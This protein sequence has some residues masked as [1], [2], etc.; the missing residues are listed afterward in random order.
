[1]KGSAV[2]IRSPASIEI[3]GKLGF[4]VG[5]FAVGTASEPEDGN[6]LEALQHA[7]HTPRFGNSAYGHPP[8][9]SSPGSREHAGASKP[10]R[11]RLLRLAAAQEL[12]PLARSTSSL[13]LSPGLPLR[14]IGGIFP[15]ASSLRAMKILPWRSAI[16]AS[17]FSRF[18][19]L[20]SWVTR[21][22]LA[23]LSSGTATTSRRSG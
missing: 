16:V 22:C 23:D 10:L 20:R 21:F 4:P 3:P 12:G 13:S 7:G 17:R 5:R 19:A 14:S 9:S 8:F 6:V 18:A 2:Q 11:Y 15:F 1:M